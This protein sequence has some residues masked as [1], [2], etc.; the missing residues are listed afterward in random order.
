MSAKSILTEARRLIAEV[1]WCQGQYRHYDSDGPSRMPIAYCAVGAISSATPFGSHDVGAYEL[2]RSTVGEITI[3]N[4]EQGRT[5]EQVLEA[6]DKA[7]ERA[8]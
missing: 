1:G 8:G 4:D 6:F 2:L 7:I 3:W 5:K